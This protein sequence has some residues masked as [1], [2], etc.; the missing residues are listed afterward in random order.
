VFQDL[1]FRNFGYASS[2]L[3]GAGDQDTGV[4]AYPFTTDLS[5]T[6]GNELRHKYLPTLESTRLLVIGTYGSTA[7]QLTVLTN[8]ISP[9]GDIFT[10]ATL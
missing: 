6:P 2:S 8:D 5:L 7:T 1:A 3:D 9:S 4:F 10:L